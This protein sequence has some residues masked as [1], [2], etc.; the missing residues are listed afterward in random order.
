MSTLI[1]E[2]FIGSMPLAHFEVLEWTTKRSEPVEGYDGFVLVYA[3][4]SEAEQKQ[5]SLTDFP[6]CDPFLPK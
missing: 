4:L 6:I 3:R 5:V 1:E 2:F